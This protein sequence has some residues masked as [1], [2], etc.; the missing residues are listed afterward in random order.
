MSAIT[1]SLVNAMLQPQNTA[2]Q[3]FN[4]INPSRST[5]VDYRPWW[6]VNTQ[7]TI[8]DQL[9]NFAISN[10]N[11]EEKGVQEIFDPGY[12]NIYLQYPNTKLQRLAD[13]ITYGL[14]DNDNKAT[15]I[16]HWVLQNFPYM[17]DEENY[18]YDELWVPPTFALA[19]GSGDCEDG[20]FL[21]HS[22]LL[23]AGI[24]HDRIRTYGGFV[25]AGEGAA[26]GGHAWTAYRRETDDEWVVLDSSYYP[27]FLHV[28]DRPLM[29]KTAM[30]RENYFYF[31]RFVWTNLEG[32]DR[33]HNPG[34]W[35]NYSA[36][37]ILE[38][39]LRFAGSFINRYA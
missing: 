26:S 3:L 13:D 19:K 10:Y 18:G 14:H 12:I 28:D 33:I 11:R 9:F 8:F 20:A 30:Y 1:G 31:N 15:A 39:K 29:R 17:S 16:I 5:S 21:V 23:H 7:A 32:V 36:N 22:L 24:D 37:G 34:A 4:I 27:N 6:A 2:Q 35:Y 25:D 38:N